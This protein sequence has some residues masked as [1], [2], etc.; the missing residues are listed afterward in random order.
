MAVP[1]EEVVRA[2]Q[3]AVGRGD[4]E[5]LVALCHP[6]VEWVPFIAQLDRRTFRGHEGIRQLVRAL[7]TIFDPFE[8]R[9]NEVEEL[10]AGRLL[11]TG[12]FRGRGRSSG[13]DVEVSVAQLW[14][15]REGKVWRVRTFP[16]AE[17]ARSAA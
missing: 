1:G 11:V 4:V 12:R 2:A 13:A 15:F 8:P 10:D 14:A 17:A 5:A 6:Q 9:V 7:W 16:D 3:A